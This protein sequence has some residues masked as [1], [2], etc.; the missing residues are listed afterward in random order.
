MK[1]PNQNKNQNKTNKQKRLHVHSSYVVSINIIAFFLVFQWALT[2]QNSPARH[3]RRS[4]SCK[5]ITQILRKCYLF[6]AISYRIM[7]K[8]QLLTY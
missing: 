3:D 8:F 7:Y 1:N 4:R 6:V 5:H 2:L